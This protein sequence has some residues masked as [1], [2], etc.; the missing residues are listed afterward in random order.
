MR[1]GRDARQTAASFQPSRMSRTSSSSILTWRMSCRLWLISTRA[2]SPESFC[3][4]PRIVK[5]CS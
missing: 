4:A 2:S 3:L 5:P 1:A